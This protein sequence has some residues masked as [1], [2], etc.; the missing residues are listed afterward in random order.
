[1]SGTLS[2]S[3]F[4]PFCE[5]WGPG[6]STASACSPEAQE[7]KDTTAEIYRDFELSQALFGEKA[8]AITELTALAQECCGQ[9]W[10]GYGAHAVEPLAVQKTKS[11]IRAIPSSFPMP[12]FAPEPDG[13]IS[14]DWMGSPSRLFSVSVSPSDRLAFTWL[15]G[16]DRGY[17]VASFDGETLPTRILDGIRAVAS[18][19]YAPFRV[20]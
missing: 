12:E 9:D 5:Q 6:D 14:L 4:H 8:Q 3:N 2:I 18:D 19:R 16:T 1:M 17:G 20:T 11:F 7:I 13:A 10:D 15:D